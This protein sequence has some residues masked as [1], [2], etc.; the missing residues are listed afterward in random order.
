MPPAKLDVVS[1]AAAPG[2]VAAA[3]VASL[4]RF[5]NPRRIVLLARTPAA[6]A[7]LAALAPNVH[8]VPEDELIPGALM[9]AR[10]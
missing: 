4:N 5:L 3:A 6:C 2:C 8:C 9:V 10:R 1:V 7:A